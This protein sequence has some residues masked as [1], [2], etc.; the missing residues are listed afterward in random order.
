[1]GNVTRDAGRKTTHQSRVEEG[2]RLQYVW[3][4]FFKQEEALAYIQ[5]Q[6][7]AMKIPWGERGRAPGRQSAD[8][9]IPGK[10]EGSW[11]ERQSDGAGKGA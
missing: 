10:A 6:L 4:D 8:E 7:Q 9:S 5:A 2:R 3:M 1:M 11:R